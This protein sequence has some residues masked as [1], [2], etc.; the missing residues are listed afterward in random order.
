MWSVFKA[1]LSIWLQTDHRLSRSVPD[2]LWGAATWSGLGLFESGNKE[3]TL[4]SSRS[5][6]NLLL[7]LFIPQLLLQNRTV[8][9]GRSR[10]N[11]S[12]FL[13]TELG[14]DR[15]LPSRHVEAETFQTYIWRRRQ[16]T[17]GRMSRWCFHQTPG[18]S[19]YHPN[20]RFLLLVI[21]SLTA[22]TSSSDW[23]KKNQKKRKRKVTEV[24][25]ISLRSMMNCQPALNKTT[26]TICQ[27]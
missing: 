19:I 15:L 2:P 24:T 27:I 20:V 6:T 10:N 23:W 17:T 8:P 1:L 3:P 16:S 14:G 12:A 25:G 18:G 4:V 22:R 11:S 7:R 26:L 5:P 21:R 13:G 9:A